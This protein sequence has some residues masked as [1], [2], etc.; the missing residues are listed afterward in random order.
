MTIEFVNELPAAKSNR[1]YKYTPSGQV[2]ETLKSRPNTWAHIRTYEEHR[3]G[4]GYVFCSQCRNGKIKALS[5]AA[6]YEVAARLNDDGS[7]AIYARY[8]GA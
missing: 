7:L 4:G 5:P 6:G 8:V 2:A 1:T 3:K